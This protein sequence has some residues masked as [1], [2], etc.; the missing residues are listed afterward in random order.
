VL[1]RTARITFTRIAA[2][3]TC[4]AQLVRHEP[5]GLYG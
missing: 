1:I 4:T 2:M 5:A 3:R